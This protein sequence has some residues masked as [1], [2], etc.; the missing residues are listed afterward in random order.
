ME[1]PHPVRGVGQSWPCRPVPWSHGAVQERQEVYSRQL[2]SSALPAL[3]PSTGLL[4]NCRAALSGPPHDS[5]P[6]S[7]PAMKKS[8]RVARPKGV[9]NE[10]GQSSVPQL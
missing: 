10:D 3:L 7:G 4:L 2:M 6:W 1:P 9:T 5:A 8:G